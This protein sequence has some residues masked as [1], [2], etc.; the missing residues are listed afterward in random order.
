MGEQIPA[1]RTPTSHAENPFERSSPSDITY[2][3]SPCP[4]TARRHPTTNDSAS[5]GLCDAN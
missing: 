3:L 2:I 4:T 5:R 1:S